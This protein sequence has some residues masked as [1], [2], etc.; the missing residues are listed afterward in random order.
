[1]AEISLQMPDLREPVAERLR[2]HI[3]AAELAAGEWLLRQAWTAS[4]QHGPV[5]QEL[6]ELAR[7]GVVM[8]IP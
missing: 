1:M 3:V 2:A 8:I 6:R 7:D 5:R 4:G